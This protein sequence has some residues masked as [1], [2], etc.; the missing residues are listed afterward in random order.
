[1]SEKDYRRKAHRAGWRLVVALLLTSALAACGR[2][3]GH[4]GSDSGGSTV[5][6]ESVR[7]SPSAL[8]IPASLSDELTAKGTYS[9]GI[10]KDVTTK[11][12]WSAVDDTVVTVGD[13]AADKGV[14]Q[15]VADGESLVRFTYNG[16]SAASRITVIPGSPQSLAISPQDPHMAMGATR[17][18]AATATYAGGVT[19]DVTDEASWSSANT[20]IVT[21]S[22]GVVT[23]GTD[24]STQISAAFGGR[25]DATT[26]TV[27]QDSLLDVTIEPAAPSVVEGAVIQLHA[28][29]HY[30]S[31]PDRD[32]TEDASWSSDATG[33][34][35]VSDA[36]GSKGQLTGVS[37]GTATV[38][39]SVGTKSVDASV[40]VTSAPSAP[41]AI[42]LSTGSNVVL[43][44]SSA[45]TTS[46]TAD[47]APND[48]QNSVVADGTAVDFSV[49]GGSLSTASAT[50][51]NGKATTTF[52]A[53]GT[54]GTAT[55]TA[56]IPS[57][58]LS[59][60][61][62]IFKVNDFADIFQV[63]TRKKDVSYI[64]NVLQKG[65]EFVVFVY[66]GSN[67][68]FQLTRLEFYNGDPVNDVFFTARPIS[69]YYIDG[70]DYLR[71]G[72]KLGYAQLA[73]P[74]HTINTL[75]DNGIGVTV[76]L[77]DQ[78]TGINFQV[79]ATFT[80]PSP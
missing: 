35:R 53:D 7:I 29:G 61:L 14:I 30:G 27:D 50:T 10:T 46:V 45:N 54:A 40:N 56:G 9:D 75:V 31:G 36:A 76:Y 26:V 73:E 13:A 74:D 22:K 3:A 15:G 59:D 23:S 48:P 79:G 17:R 21:V 80:T 25:N 77:R 71:K 11:G 19:W 43:I 66:N 58:G 41:A 1:M 38:T 60:D 70:G 18:L 62:Q 6:L 34:A 52:T 72:I 8:T 65:S 32:V 24:G 2:S 78:R 28:T 39:A 69:T 47:V 42:T 51:V 12:E 49:A 63:A 4:S 33:V 16:K 20:G 44:G 57:A 68:P 64:G 67:R 55:V 5:T 37:S